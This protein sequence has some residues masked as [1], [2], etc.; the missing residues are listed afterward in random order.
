MDDLIQESI[1]K[2]IADKNERQVQKVKYEAEKPLREAKK[3]YQSKCDFYDELYAKISE[4]KLVDA[5][6]KATIKGKNYLI[7]DIALFLIPFYGEFRRKKLV[8]KFDPYGKGTIYDILTKSL[9]AGYEVLDNE[10]S[11]FYDY[12]LGIS[13]GEISC[14][15]RF[16]Y[17]L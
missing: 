11:V 13:W 3:K 14:W 4:T 6:A 17:N 5:I 16:N 15:D 10:S 8:H 12:T 7:L 9:P 2:Q 1:K